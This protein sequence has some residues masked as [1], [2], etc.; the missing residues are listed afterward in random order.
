MRSGGADDRF[1][2]Q[3]RSLGVRGRDPTWRG[4]ELTRAARVWWAVVTVTTVGYGDLYPQSVGGRLVGIAR[5][6]V[7][8]GSSPSL[9][10]QLR[11]AS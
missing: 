2:G 5:M 10:P 6:L 8:I 9:L 7:G 11:L 4:I 3:A 1:E